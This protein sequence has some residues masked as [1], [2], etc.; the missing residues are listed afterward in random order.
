MTST[1]MTQFN[2]KDWFSRRVMAEGLVSSSGERGG[3]GLVDV[4]RDLDP[5]VEPEVVEGVLGA[6]F[7]SLPAAV[8]AQKLEEVLLAQDMCYVQVLE[9]VDAEA[10]VAAGMSRGAAMM[11]LRAIRPPVVRAVALGGLEGLTGLRQA[12]RETLRTFPGLEKTGYPGVRGWRAYV[13]A[14]IAFVQPAVG[15]GT[16]ALM[17]KVM[18]DPGAKVPEDWVRGGSADR[19]LHQAMVN[20]GAGSMPEALALAL[21][22]SDYEEQA[23]LAVFYFITRRVLCVSDKA[24][25]ER[26]RQ[27]TDPAAVDEQAKFALSKRL[28]EWKQVRGW[29]ADNGCEQSRVQCNLSLDKLVA[30]LP[31]V[32]QALAALDARYVGQPTPLDEN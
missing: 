1:V 14:L 21:D 13:P 24:V 16:V 27:F 19:A 15:D 28:Q 20:Q 25:G 4:L 26:Q 17:R 29:L 22:Q 10:L 11:V 2:Y 9:Q 5:E 31:H 30:R 6:L 8:R 12:P 7:L 3:G 18:A 23:G 32:V